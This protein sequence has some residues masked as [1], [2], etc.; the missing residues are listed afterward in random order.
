MV[1][2]GYILSK[3]KGLTIGAK[4]Y[5]GFVD[6]VKYISGSNNSSF[7]VKINI[8]IGREKAA[9]KAAEKDLGN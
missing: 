9:M 5:Y 3:G 2:L 6:V 8:P 7:L 4:Y 1:G